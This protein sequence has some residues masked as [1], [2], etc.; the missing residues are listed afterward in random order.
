MRLLDYLTGLVSL[1]ALPFIAW[2][3]VNQSPQSAAMLEAR[4][5]AKAL[6]SL[7]LAGIEWANVEMDGQ[8]AILTGAA[9]SEDAVPEAAS[10]VLRS[11]GG[12]GLLFGGVSQITA[13][14]E[15]AAPVWPY[16]WRAEKTADG[17]FIL[18]GHV[19]SKAVQ[20]ILMEEAG[21][22]SRGPVIN[23]MKLAAGAPEG[24]WQGIAR[25][26]IGQLAELKSGQAELA[27]Y[28]LTLRGTAPDDAVRAA[29]PATIHGVAAPFRGA[30]VLDGVPFWS[31]GI[32]DGAMVL[33]GLAPTDPVRR[34]LIAAAKK[35]FDGEIRDEMVVADTQV[36]DWVDGATSG[37]ARF[38]DFEEGRMAFDPVAGGF[39]V[40]GAATPGTIQLLRQDLTATAGDWR[41]VILAEA[42]APAEVAALTA[43]AEPAPLRC[44]AGLNQLLTSGEVSFEPGQAR[45]RRESAAALDQFAA[46]AQGCGTMELSIDDDALNQARAS[47]I[48][49]YLEG[50]GVHRPALAAIGSGTADGAQVMD[51]GA[52]QTTLRPLEFTKR[53]RSGQ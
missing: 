53:E 26:A 19:P 43:A 4:L 21:L 18:S 24:N 34:A 31:A 5:E 44:E 25:L 17:G 48:A 7:R 50:A 9:P 30:A 40:E 15:A 2:W 22:V 3:G 51:S 10:I 12:G 33:S 41:V 27:G 29:V 23:D 20:M 32:K 1:V 35:G 47:A 6:Q 52:P 16:V 49:D 45:F 14:V 28:A 8:T 38:A 36:T 46:L 42:S 37:L 11:S 39:I 13:R